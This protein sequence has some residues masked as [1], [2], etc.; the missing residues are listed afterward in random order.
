MLTKTD[1]LAPETVQEVRQW[2]ETQAPGVPVVEVVGGETPP[3]IILGWPGQRMRLVAE[4][5]PPY[6]MP[7]DEWTITPFCAGYLHRGGSPRSRRAGGR[8]GHVLSAGVVRAKGTFY[9]ADVPGEQVILQVAGRRLEWQTGAPGET[10]APIRAL[11]L[12]G[13]CGFVDAG[14]L[15]GGRASFLH[16]HAQ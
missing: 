4:Q 13:L 3:A 12:I 11:V 2:L 7:G 9:L 16:P 15:C 14:S 5:E 8:H 1:L 6:Y 10:L